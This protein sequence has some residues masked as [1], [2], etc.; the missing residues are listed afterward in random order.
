[1]KPRPK[2]RSKIGAVLLTLSCLELQVQQSLA[3]PGELAAEVTAGGD[4]PL[5]CP[6]ACGI[7]YTVD[8]TGDGHNV[9]PVT[10]CNDGTNHCTL[11]AAIEAANGH[12][13]DDGI[14]FNIPTTGNNCDASG[15]CTINLGAAL[16]D[17][18]D[19]VTITGPGA[20]KLSVTRNSSSSFR[21]FNV[22]APGLVSFSGMTISKGAAPINGN[23]GGINKTGAGTV[24]VTNC[25]ISNNQA[26]AVGGGGGINN[27]SSG[28]INLTNSTV[29]ANSAGDGGGI[30]SNGGTVNITGS[31]VSDNTADSN[32]GAFSGSGHGGGL[33]VIA[34]TVT[35]TNSALTGNSA[36]DTGGGGN[37]I[38]GGGIYIAAGT[39][40]FTNSTLSGNSANLDGGGIYN[41]S[42]LNVSNSTLTGNTAIV[43]GGIYNDSAGSATI[44]S[45]LIA[46]NGSITHNFNGSFISG[47]FNLIDNNDGSNFPAGNPNANNDVVGTKAAPLDAKLDPAGLQDNGGRTKTIALQSNSPAINKGGSPNAPARDQ[48]NYV[49]PDTADTGA[50]EFAGT[51]PVTLA[52]IS[53]RLAVQTGDNV[54]IGGFIVTGTHQKK[55]ILRAIGP[56]LTLPGKLADPILELYQGNTLLESNDNWMDSPNRQMI[57]DST[58]PPDNSLESAIV[59]VLAP[60]AYTAIVR[61]V[62]NGTGIGV[63]EAYDL[64]R[65]LDSKLANI[66]TRGPVQTGDNVLFAG[67]IVSGPDSQKVIIRALGPS[68]PVPGALADPTLELHDGN[69]ATLEANDNWVDS[70]NK[71]AIIDSTIPPPNNMESA[72]VRTLTPAGYTAIVRGA[73]NSTGVAVVEVYALN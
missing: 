33:L 61:G 10:Q 34:G 71:Q 46:L 8:S 64:D 23:G 3:L 11:R 29:S 65:T 42:A 4:A 36:R 15:N 31:T 2:F 48:R 39:A 60:G 43:G 72:I 14:F 37:T 66:S 49:R 50:F 68:V 16:P 40:N 18:S 12:A 45:S 1:V 44:K 26:L 25:T 69:G 30:R 70:P 62:N 32:S 59:R 5:T 6:P 58:I 54:L 35:V 73:N 21:I 22:T 9:G 57:I 27:D 47:G 7:G 41:K 63:V 20:D 51:I 53:T 67:F 24:N 38:N 19:N 28:T 52:N 13:G 56:S 17:L 55:V